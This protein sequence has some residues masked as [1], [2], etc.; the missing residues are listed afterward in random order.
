MVEQIVAPVF[1]IVVGMIAAFGSRRFVERIAA[2]RAIQI[3]DYPRSVLA[4]RI[5]H[6][7]IGLG[8]VCFGLVLLIKG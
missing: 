5:M 2:R 4:V 1:L 3:N 6:V 8:F 7:V